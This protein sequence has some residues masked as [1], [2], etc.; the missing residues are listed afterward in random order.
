LKAYAGFASILPIILILIL[1]NFISKIV[2]SGT[3]QYKLLALSLTIS[4]YS[5]NVS[6]KFMI[7]IFN[8]KACT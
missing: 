2:K 7:G 8:R 4:V 1:A 3:N 5:L 6:R